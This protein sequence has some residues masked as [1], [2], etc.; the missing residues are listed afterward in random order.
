MSRPQFPSINSQTLDIAVPAIAPPQPNQVAGSYNVALNT[1]FTKANAISIL[2]TADQAWVQLVLTL[3]TAGPVEISSS[4]NFKPFLSGK[5]Q[6]LATNVPLLF[7]V[8]KG[9]KVYIGAPAVERVKVTIQP[10][11][12]LEQITGSAAAAAKALFDLIARR[13]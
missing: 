7:S 10:L 6:A 2:Y 12:W 5:A 1:F 9:N 11:P 3:E 8:P 4:P 13:K